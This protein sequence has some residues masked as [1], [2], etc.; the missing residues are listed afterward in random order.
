MEGL[1]TKPGDIVT[2][3]FPYIDDEAGFKARPALVI[4]SPVP[5]VSI[6]CE[7]TTNLM[8]RPHAIALTPNDFRDGNLRKQSVIR[9]DVIVTMHNTR[10]K[11]R[12]GSVTDAKLSEVLGVVTAILHG[13]VN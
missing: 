10:L 5:N 3:K 2:V 6:L 7:I 12:A 9:A 4:A 13:K 11:E 8:D 1:V